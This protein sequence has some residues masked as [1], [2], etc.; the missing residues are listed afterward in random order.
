[1]SDGE[2]AQVRPP[3]PGSVGGGSWR[4]CYALW[5]REITGFLRQRSRIMGALGTPLLFWLLAGAGLGQSFRM[6]AASDGTSYLEFSFTG[7]LAAIL[8]FTA[9]FSTITII[10]DRRQGF[11]QGVLVAPVS[12]ITIALGIISGATTLAVGHAL[13]FYLLAPFVGIAVGIKSVAATLG[14]LVLLALALSSLG[15]LVAWRVRSTQGFHAVMNLVLVPMLI[16]SGAFFPVDGAATWLRAAVMVNPL[17]YGVYVLRSAVHAET[18]T[19]ASGGPAGLVVSLAVSLV[20]AVALLALAT[21][22]AAR[23]TSQVFE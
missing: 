14:A 4:P 22:A 17:T 10:D 19:A 13:V 23:Q 12:R 6:P 11:L 21:R 20:F 7:A 9:I 18:L 1:M 2:R 8:L 15:F 3:A 5:R 16:L